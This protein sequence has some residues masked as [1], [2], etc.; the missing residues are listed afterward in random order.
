MPSLR[1][2]SK[3]PSYAL[4]VTGLEGLSSDEERDSD[5]SQAEG[6]RAGPRRRATS[7]AS[8]DF[9]PKEATQSKKKGKG[10]AISVDDDSGSEFEGASS[11]EE[12]DDMADDVVDENEQE[13][14]EK[15]DIEKEEDVEED[16]LVAHDT[17]LVR[18]R[19]RTTPSAFTNAPSHSN[20]A[21]YVQS[22]A[23]LIPQQYRQLIVKHAEVIAAPFRGKP[24]AQP[25]ERDYKA[26][27]LDPGVMP[28][29][30]GTP[31]VTR[32]KKEVRG[33]EGAQVIYDQKLGR[34]ALDE[35]EEKLNRQTRM[36]MVLRY[37]SLLAPW[38]VWQGDGWWPEMAPGH[39]AVTRQGVGAVAKGTPTTAEG[40]MRRDEVRLGLDRVGR[41]TID[42]MNMLSKE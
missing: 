4:L 5:A 30:P 18:P 26:R 23:N 24:S 22:E 37:V 7:G 9:D 19:P 41:Y 14:D 15:E 21:A 20:Q 27:S 6:S 25:K 42:Q 39:P 33:R 36:A 11:E 29:G 8:I 10:K 40:W 31:Y 13:E 17:P 38:Q 3:R 12:D 2:R 32:L 1:E 35:D 34:G 28:F 16:E